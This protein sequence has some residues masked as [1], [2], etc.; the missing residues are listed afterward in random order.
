M[1]CYKE[2]EDIDKEEDERDR[3]ETGCVAVVKTKEEGD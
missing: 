1:V 2:E 3:T